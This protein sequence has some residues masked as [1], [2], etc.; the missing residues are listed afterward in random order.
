MYV[1]CSNKFY[2]VLLGACCLFN[3]KMVHYGNRDHGTSCLNIFKLARINE[4][5]GGSEAHYLLLGAV[6]IWS[7]PGIPHGPRSPGG[8]CGTAVA[9]AVLS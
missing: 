1:V 9:G 7:Q 3:Y 6:H 8:L 2:S 5:V 4:E